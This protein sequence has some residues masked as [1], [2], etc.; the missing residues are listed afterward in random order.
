MCCLRRFAHFKSYLRG[1]KV[2]IEKSLNIK[3]R[4]SNKSTGIGS[5]KVDDPRRIPDEDIL[6]SDT[7]RRDG[8]SISYR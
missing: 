2:E 5:T 3:E 4:S 1:R 6:L 7:M 8:G